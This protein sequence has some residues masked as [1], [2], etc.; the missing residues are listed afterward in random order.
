[1][2][3]AG[4]LF[5]RQRGALVRLL[6]GGGLETDG[7]T[8]NPGLGRPQAGGQEGSGAAGS[9]FD[10]VDALHWRGPGVAGGFPGGALGGLETSGGGAVF[11]GSSVGRAGTVG[12]E[13]RRSALLGNE[14]E[15][16]HSVG[17]PSGGEWAASGLPGVLDDAEAQFVPGGGD[18]LAEG[19]RNLFGGAL[20]GGGR[21][22]PVSMAEDVLAENRSRLDVEAVPVRAAGQQG[23]KLETAAAWNT[24]GAVLDGAVNPLQ[25]RDGLDSNLGRL[26]GGMGRGTVDAVSGGGLDG[27]LAPGG[28][29]AALQQMPVLS[30]GEL[31]VGNAQSLSK[32]FQRDAR[33]YDGGF[34]LF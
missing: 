6:L 32:V 10:E 21:G 7:G 9:V 25:I 3:F 19:Y 27:G 31:S 8:E 29:E 30:G 2:D 15:R 26:A 23:G 33:R 1:M 16:L 5:E 11:G 34:S 4:A 18:G 12:D 20:A 14:V 28:R 13:T 17:R 22:M 24:G